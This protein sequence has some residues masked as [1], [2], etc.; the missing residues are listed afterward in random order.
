M[1][2]LTVIP[3]SK[4]LPHGELT[5]FSP[6]DIP[7]GYLVSVPLRKKNIPALVIT[8]VDLATTKSELKTA[9]FSLKK[10]TKV[11]GPS[12]FDPLFMDSCIELA[13]HLLVPPG[14]VIRSVLPNI[15]FD[16]YDGLKKAWIP[17]KEDAKKTIYKEEILLLQAPHEER[18]HYY[19]TYVRER[20]AQ[21]KSVLLLTPTKA[22]A[23]E[24]HK[25]LERGVEHATILIH[26]DV[27]EKILTKRIVDAV[28]QPHP[29]LIIATPFYIGI[30]RKDLG[31]II[32]EEEHS[33]Q[34]TERERPYVDI[35]TLAQIYSVKKNMPIILGGTLT[36]IESYGRFCDREIGSTQTPNFRLHKDLSVHIVTPLPEAK[37]KKGEWVSI[38]PQTISAIEAA[39]LNKKRILVYSLR[40]GF[41][42]ET[43][44]NDC[45]TLVVCDTCAIPLVLYG[46]TREEKI[47]KCS[48]CKKTY[49]AKTKCSLCG[50]WHLV[51]LGIGIERV[52]S[53]LKSLF[54]DVPVV[55]E[56]EPLTSKK[57]SDAFK[58]KISATPVI[59]V[60]TESLLAH[61]KD[62]KPDLSIIASI[63]SLFS[64]PSF[65]IGERIMQMFEKIANL[66]K[67]TIVI[68]TRQPEE[69]VISAFAKK[70]MQDFYVKE[71]EE[72]RMLGYPPYATLI[73]MSIATK[74]PLS[75][76]IQETIQSLFTGYKVGIFPAF[77]KQVKGMYI[78]HMVLRLPKKTWGIAELSPG[79]GHDTSLPE[80]IGMLPEQWHIRVDPED[81]L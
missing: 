34:Y 71:L 27:S 79:A 21:K 44:C 33:P 6:H 18:I 39:I 20:F 35:R 60:G 28:T 63:D 12:V 2:T 38:E 68:Q 54:P 81:L 24:L 13:E 42:T 59:L 45:K 8:S 69:P 40:K 32:I 73:K 80:R 37:K 7:A 78:S 43:M 48:R 26:N 23:E 16:I 17:E 1:K 61:I 46:E 62:H 29:V 58:E 25:E 52:A 72:R 53:D 10:I 47:F 3:L 74:K 22:Q 9:Q 5:Y 75:E 31:A 56:G 4:G 65:H 14:S 11:L 76:K 67:E 50:S 64:L 15:L 66:T 51:P 41:A 49:D 19:R 70:N 77:I 57:R 55:F 30:P 36:R